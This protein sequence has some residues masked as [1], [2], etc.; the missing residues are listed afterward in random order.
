MIL[1]IFNIC[2]LI[3]SVLLSANFAHS[4]SS[5]DFVQLNN[6]VNGAYLSITIN[7]IMGYSMFMV[8]IGN[9]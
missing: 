1:P 5:T 2:L 7:L 3:L 4:F 6:P 9:Y 8:K